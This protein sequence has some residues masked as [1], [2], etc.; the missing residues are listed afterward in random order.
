MNTLSFTAAGKILGK[1]PAA[2]SLPPIVTCPGATRYCRSLCYAQHGRCAMPMTTRTWRRNLDIVKKNPEM[3]FSLPE[4]EIFRIHVSGDFFSQHY[5]NVWSQV[6]ASRPWQKFW[7]YTRS[8]SLDLRPLIDLPNLSLFLSVD[9]ENK[10]RALNLKSRFPSLRL[11]FSPWQH[12]WFKPKA[13]PCPAVTGQINPIAACNT[14]RFCI[15]KNKGDVLFP[16]H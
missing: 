8:F 4:T 14:C 12:S 6:I 2:F 1:T 3:L 13:L 10:V 7:C 16:K 11:A 15:N 5:L 9:P